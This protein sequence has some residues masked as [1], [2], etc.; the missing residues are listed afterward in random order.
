MG[1][2]ILTVDDTGEPRDWTGGSRN[3][4]LET[5][6]VVAPRSSRPVD[7]GA[8]EV[9]ATRT[10]AVVGVDRER[11]G[12]GDKAGRGGRLGSG[13]L[14]GRLVGR[15]GEE[16]ALVGVAPAWHLA[17][18]DG[19]LDPAHAGHRGGTGGGSLRLRRRARLH[20]DGGQWDAIGRRRQR[21]KRRLGD[22]A[23]MAAASGRSGVGASRASGER[24]RIGRSYS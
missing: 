2:A 16:D 7:P 12:E 18:R 9:R 6:T 15:G 22:Q 17:Q 21:R 23:K 8:I 11:V 20:G 10:G 3:L 1:W 5:R 19:R 24:E 13:A 14:H 4:I